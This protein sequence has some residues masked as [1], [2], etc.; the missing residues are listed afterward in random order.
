VNAQDATAGKLNKEVTLNS[1]CC[2]SINVKTILRKRNRVAS[3]KKPGKSR[4]Y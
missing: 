1:A 3:N 2:E 4:E